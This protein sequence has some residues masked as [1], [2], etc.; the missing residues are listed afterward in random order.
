[1]PPLSETW[2]EEDERK[3]RHAVAFT[4]SRPSEA[5]ESSKVQI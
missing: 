2:M 5:Y 3:L 1:M 4:N